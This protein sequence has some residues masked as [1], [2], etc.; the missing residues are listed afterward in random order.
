MNTNKRDMVGVVALAC[1]AAVLFISSVEIADEQGTAELKGQGAKPAAWKG[2]GAKP[3]ASS[4]TDNTWDTPWVKA[5]AND[6]S[7]AY[8]SDATAKAGEVV[9]ECWGGLKTTSKDASD[10]SSVHKKYMAT[11]AGKASKK[12]KPGGTM[13]VNTQEVRNLC[14]TSLHIPIVLLSSRLLFSSLSLSLPLLSLS[15][16]SRPLVSLSRSISLSFSLCSFSLS[17]SLSLSH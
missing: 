6:Q 12:G 8:W 17:L 9:I 3:A 11:R 14:F 15:L 7:F 4:G 10:C 5:H 13:R 2:Q 16:D 1:C